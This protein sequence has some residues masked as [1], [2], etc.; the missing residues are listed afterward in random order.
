MGYPI[1][2]DA[3]FK[4][5][6]QPMRFEA[7]VEECIVTEG[8]IPKDL[9]GGFYRV[10][11]TWKRPTKQGTNGLLAMDGMV[12]GLVLENGRADFRNRW[13]RTPKYQLEEEHGRGMF[14]WTDG[15]WHDWRSFGLGDVQRD[16]YTTGVPQGTNNVNIFPFAGKMIATADSVGAPIAI[17][18]ITLETVGAVSWSSKLSAGLHEKAAF[19][20][21]G[22][23]AHPKWDHETGILYGWT[24]RDTKPY[25]TLHVVRPDGGVLSRDIDDAP[26]NSVAHDIWL[27]P[28]HVVM[29]FQPFLVDKARILK[30]RSVYAW[31]PELPIVLALIPRHDL[32]API[33]W[34]TMDIEAQYIMHTMSANVTGDR[35]TLD[36]PIFNR[37]P[38]PFEQDFADGDDVA[39]FFSIAKSELG[40]WS[41]DLGTGA[42]SS[43]RLSDRPSELPK[44][45]ERFYGRGYRWG[46]QVGGVVK[47]AGM[48]MNSLV[49][50]DMQTLSDQEYRIRTDQPAA[51]LEATFVPRTPDAPEGDGWLI[52][53]VSW[54]AEKRGEYQ[55]FDTHDIT[56][57]P[58]ARIELPFALGWTAHGHWM[59]FRG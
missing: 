11:P 41:V 27:T 5:P 4:G 15:E 9:A 56:V 59:D 48:S 31:E 20:D 51:V 37:P 29:P 28:E 1:P 21:A 40:R 19:G 45:D 57:G 54:W 55:I 33:R 49:V 35:L 30:G 2:V 58:I 24:Y 42:T 36:G 7:T 23:T 44:V 25:V 3:R 10:G 12:Q 22:F 32:A 52:V 46:Y 50:T 13:V 53:P 26:Y 14:T 34:V 18:P 43:E 39:L 6:F 38:F 47:R 16:R 8:E 17:D